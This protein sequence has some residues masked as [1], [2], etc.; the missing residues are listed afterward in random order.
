MAIADEIAKALGVSVD[1]VQPVVDDLG[2][3]QQEAVLAAAKGEDLSFSQ[4]AGQQ[5]IRILADQPSRAT[6]GASEAFSNAFKVGVPATAGVAGGAFAAGKFF[7]S[8]QAK[9]E[10]MAREDQAEAMKQLLT[11]KHLTGKQK[12]RIFRQLASK[13]FFGFS[14]GEGQ[15]GDRGILARITGAI[16]LGDMSLVETVIVL[17]VLYFVGKALVEYAGSGSSSGGGN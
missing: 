3:A 14:G 17:V 11:D 2:R 10:Q 15:G 1:E 13:G 16:G 6:T 8:Q 12:A 5:G 9:Y 7:E 4:R